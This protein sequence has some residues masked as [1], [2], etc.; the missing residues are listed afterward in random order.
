MGRSPRPN[1][2]VFGDNVNASVW[3]GELGFSFQIVL[4][5]WVSGTEAR[6]SGDTAHHWASDAAANYRVPF[7]VG[8]GALGRQG[9]AVIA[10]YPVRD[11][12]SRGGAVWLSEGISDYSASSLSSCDRN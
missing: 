5:R 3:G 2:G 7:R 12:S 4:G 8:H 6:P 9:G 1:E 11:G 10:A